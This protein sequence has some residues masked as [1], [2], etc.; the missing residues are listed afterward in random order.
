M[1]PGDSDDSLAGIQIFPLHLGRNRIPPR[2]VGCSVHRPD[3]VQ[4]IRHLPDLFHK[5]GQAEAGQ[6]LAGRVGGLDLLARRAGSQAG[7]D[8][9]PQTREEKAKDRIARLRRPEGHVP[10][11]RQHLGHQGAQVGLGGSG[12][13]AAR[14][15]GG[16]GAVDGGL[17]GGVVGLEDGHDA[18]CLRLPRRPHVPLQEVL[19]LQQ[20][21]PHGDDALDRGRHLVDAGLVEAEHLRDLLGADGRGLREDVHEHLGVYLGRRRPRL[22]VVGALDVA[23]LHLGRDLGRRRPPGRLGHRQVVLLVPELLAEPLG[24]VRDGRFDQLRGRNLEQVVDVVAQHDV[25]EPIQGLDPVDHAAVAQLVLDQIPDLVVPE[26]RAQLGQEGRHGREELF[27]GE[28]AHFELPLR[29]VHVQDLADQVVHRVPLLERTLQLVLDVAGPEHEHPKVCLRRR[30]PHRRPHLEIE[31]LGEGGLLLHVLLGRDL[32]LLVDGQLVHDDAVVW[33]QPVEAGLDGCRRSGAGGGG[34]GSP[35]ALAGRRRGRREH[36][37]RIRGRDEAAR[38]RLG[39]S[40]HA[41]A[42]ELAVLDALA[43]ERGRRIVRRLLDGVEDGVQL[44]HLHQHDLDE[45]VGVPRLPGDERV[46]E[47]RVRL[48]ERRVQ[49]R[50]HGVPVGRGQP[51]EDVF[52]GDEDVLCL[53]DQVLQLGVVELRRGQPVAAELPVVVPVL[54]A[55]V[56]AVEHLVGVAEDEEGAEERADRGHFLDGAR[57]PLLEPA[58]PEE[59]GGDEEDL[60]PGKQLDHG[61]KGRVPDAV[62]AEAEGVELEHNLPPG[63]PAPP[64]LDLGGRLVVAHGRRVVQVAR[65]GGGVGMG[66]QRLGRLPGDDALP[67]SALHGGLVSKLLPPPLRLGHALLHLRLHLRNLLLAPLLGRLG[68]LLGLVDLLG[69][70]GHDF[71][72]VAL[73]RLLRRQRALL[74]GCLPAGRRLGQGSPQADLFGVSGPVGQA[75]AAVLQEVCPANVLRGV[76]ALVAV[77]A[78][79]RLDGRAAR[80]GGRDGVAA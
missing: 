4:Q 34:G 35:T 28:A 40:G 56:D 79:G 54:G 70:A 1:R 46:V 19:A 76:L 58:D 69:A 80:V 73:P 7:Q 30:I 23:P 8:V 37:R 29:D 66:H 62:D 72:Q 11:R 74:R 26:R 71:G 67:P 14:L 38:R 51:G 17:H 13:G 55:L 42:H 53:V 36:L 10:A 45:G 43:V 39:V 24:L 22:G 3:L 33:N 9:A 44:H 25:D 2:A 5:L 41:L 12:H 6:L 63:A 52:K 27:V 64:R 31:G 50:G 15:Q 77:A 61:V 75:S 47:D 59:R 20:H 16:H 65:G 18:R 60:F 49:R 68:D 21:G 48:R 32:V 57:L 78:A